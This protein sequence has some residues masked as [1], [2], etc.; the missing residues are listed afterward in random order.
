[1]KNFKGLALTFMLVM[2]AANVNA[3]DDNNP[4]QISIGLNAVDV[5]PI[6][7]SS[8]QGELFDEFF[9]VTRWTF[10]YP[11][12]S[13]KLSKLRRVKYNDVI[14]LFKISPLA[15]DRPK[16]PVPMIAIF[17]LFSF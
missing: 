15:M 13:S 2:F 17:I 11:S 12:N 8:P 9:T 5:Y 10:L 1:M 7:E 3:Q 6:G 16:F 4:W 14:A